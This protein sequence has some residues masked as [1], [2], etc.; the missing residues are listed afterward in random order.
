MCSKDSLAV[1]SSQKSRSGRYRSVP[2]FSTSIPQRRSRII[3]AV[4]VGGNCT[5]PSFWKAYF[6]QRSS[7]V[8]SPKF[9]KRCSFWASKNGTQRQKIFFP[10]PFLLLVVKWLLKGKALPG[11]LDVGD[12][13]GSGKMRPFSRKASPR[14]GSTSQLT[15]CVRY[16]EGMPGYEGDIVVSVSTV[17]QSSSRLAAGVNASVRCVRMHSSLD[18]IRITAERQCSV[19]PALITANAGLE[20]TSSEPSR[21]S[22]IFIST[23]PL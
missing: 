21:L 3:S 23:Q 12:D 16:T 15:M 20:R 19:S 4:S 17:R 14:W 8:A 11:E 22:P 7:A 9:T 18:K 5:T 10:L 6:A 13:S 1:R 2:Y